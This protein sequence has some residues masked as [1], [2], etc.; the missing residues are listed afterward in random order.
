MNNA[1]IRDK[2]VESVI[3][4]T[5]EREAALIRQIQAIEDIAGSE[6]WSTLK[7]EIFDD[8]LTRLERE[9][10]EEAKMENPNTNK[11]NRITGEM[12][13]AERFS[14]L[15][16]LKDAQRVE[17]QGIRKRNHEQ[18]DFVRNDRHGGRNGSSISHDSH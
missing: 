6:S 3:E 9:L 14:D 16:K 1:S 10:R 4:K 13:W 15:E 18:K 11:L 5:Q 17:L 2:T 7:T 8:L 12:K